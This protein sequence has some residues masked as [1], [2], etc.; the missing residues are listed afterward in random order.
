MVDAGR[1]RVR[2]VHDHARQHGGE[3]RPAH[4][5][6]RLR[7]RPLRARVGRQRLR[8]HV[9]RADADR[10]KARRSPRSAA[11]LHRRARDLHPRLARLRPGDE[12]RVP[13]RRPRRA[14]SRLGADEPRDALDHHRH[15]PAAP[16]RDGNWPLGRCLGDGARNRPAPR[17]PDHRPH[18][19]E[20]GLLHQR[21]DRDPRDRRRPARHR[22]VAR[23]VRG[24]APRPPR[25]G[26]VGDRPL[27]AHLRPDR[28][29]RARLDVA[30]H[31][32]AVCHRSRRL[33]RLHR[34]RAAPE[35]AD[36][37]PLALP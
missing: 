5:R 1:G 18:P 33:R 35:G 32:L 15:V 36:A 12:R 8:P 37:R 31:P 30:A 4:D 26:R 6:A 9:R 25:A 2:P 11:N 10:R 22:R 29:Q 28:G 21:A 7:N 3:R 16:A 24:P 19:L 20:L 34:A 14:G 23:H 13:D 17:W 27:R